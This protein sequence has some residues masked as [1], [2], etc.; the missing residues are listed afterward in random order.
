MT[1]RL[2]EAA[3]RE[4]IEA[5]QA[6]MKLKDVA[7]RYGISESSVKRIIA[8]GGAPRSKYSQADETLY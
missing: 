8:S 2:G 6:G 1:D 3:V 4:I 7:K 5:R